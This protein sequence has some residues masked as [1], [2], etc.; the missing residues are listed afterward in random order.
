[1]GHCTDI[2]VIGSKPEMSQSQNGGQ[3]WHNLGVGTLMCGMVTDLELGFQR[4][5]IY[6][7]L[8]EAL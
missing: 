6:S 7:D 1:M 2:P 8:Y 5:V 4:Q 3:K